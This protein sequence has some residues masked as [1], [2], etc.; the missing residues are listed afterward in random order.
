MS[1]T[2]ILQ[3]L[4]TLTAAFVT[5]A[6]MT[7]ARLTR[8]QMCERLGIS[9]NTLT[10]HIASGD[11][12]APF[13]DGKWLLYRVIQWERDREAERVAFAVRP[14]GHHLYRHFDEGGKLLYVGISVHAVSRLAS[15]KQ[16]SPWVWSVARMEI[17]TFPTRQE[18]EEAEREAIRTER[19]LFNSTHG[20]K[21]VRARSLEQL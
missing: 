1:E 12:P 19:P 6:R 3:R 13:L 7:G 5:L 8:T 2:A 18:A 9:S 15:H 10:A 17:Q 16:T 14:K 11:A 4:D 21:A 20:D